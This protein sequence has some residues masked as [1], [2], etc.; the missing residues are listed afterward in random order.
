M[1][2][3]WIWR[4]KM[5]EG[6]LWARIIDSIHSDSW[7]SRPESIVNSYSCVWKDIVRCNADIGDEGIKVINLIK[8][9]LGNEEKLQFWNDAWNGDENF[10][11]KYPRLYNLETEKSVKVANRMSSIGSNWKWRR[12]VRE[13]RE[14]EEL[15]NIQLR[16]YLEVL[17][18]TVQE[19]DNFKYRWDR[20]IPIKANILN[21]R[22]TCGRIPVRVVL[23]KMGINSQSQ[24]CP[25]CES[26]PESIEHVFLGCLVAQELWKFIGAWWNIGIP[27]F[28]E[29]VEV[30]KWIS[31]SSRSNTIRR[32]VFVS[33]SALFK[34]LWDHRNGAI[35]DNKI[36]SINIPCQKIQEV[37]FNWLESRVK[38]DVIDWSSWKSRPYVKM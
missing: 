36:T 27:D 23:A 14:K 1:L 17:E 9:K 34:S 20:S 11:S 33:I 2:A 26:E 37:S 5:E 13:G 24:Y 6:L 3:K 29:V 35:F 32:R 30:F 8:A 16:W 15:E 4:F 18:R 7:F 28:Q 38:K 31:K 10:K 21:W 19:D 12:T 25:F 22:I